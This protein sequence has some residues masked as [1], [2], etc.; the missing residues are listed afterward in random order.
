MIYGL[1]TLAAVK[2]SKRAKRWALPAMGIFYRT[3]GDARETIQL[4]TK[5][6]KIIRVH[7]LWRDDHKFTRK[8]IKKARRRGTRVKALA[9]L[10]P[11]TKFY[12]SPF[13]EHMLDES[14]AKNMMKE[15]SVALPGLEIVN[16]PSDR[17][18]IVDGV[19]NEIHSSD[20][21]V[22]IGRFFYSFDGLDILEHDTD[23]GRYKRR[24]RDAEIFFGWI[25][26]FNLKAHQG[27]KTA[28]KRR[29]VKPTIKQFKRVRN[30]LLEN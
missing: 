12:Y 5:S 30:Q 23:V 18:A 16:T 17:G 1:D 11:D 13:C 29:T 14:E 10:N 20:M 25:S 19:I 6:C 4:L 8:D 28:R 2:Y 15:I 21:R 7:G 27:D 9:K 3:F 24:Y 22:P 26:Q